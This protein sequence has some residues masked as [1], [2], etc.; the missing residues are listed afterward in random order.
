MGRTCVNIIGNLL[1]TV[2]VG[3]F[4]QTI[5]LSSSQTLSGRKWSDC[6]AFSLV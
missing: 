3:L 6:R 1:T 2:V 4:G 5:F